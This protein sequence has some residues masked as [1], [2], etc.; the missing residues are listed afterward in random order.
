MRPFARC[1][2][3]SIAGAVALIGA[4]ART[5]SGSLG[6]SSSPSSDAT[7]VAL[8]DSWIDAVGGSDHIALMVEA[9]FTLTTEMYDAALGRLR[10]TRPR[11][12]TIAQ[13]PGVLA[14]RI[15]RWEGDDLIVQMWDGRAAQA[16]KNSMPLTSSDRDFQEVEYV[17]GE[18]NYWIRLPH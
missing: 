13:Q 17:A 3:P 7:A 9:R 5:S 6:Q 12:V 4:L 1:D 11:Y 18:V 15:E 10:R 8:M 16:F 2:A 14:A